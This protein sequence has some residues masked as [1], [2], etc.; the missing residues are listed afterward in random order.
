MEPIKEIWTSSYTL[1]EQASQKERTGL[2]IK[3][4]FSKGII[5]YNSIQPLS[6]F[7]EGMLSDYI[8]ILK[9]IPSKNIQK[10]KQAIW[11]DTILQ[12]AYMDATARSKGQSLLFGYPL[13]QS[14][15][16]ISNINLWNSLDE[17]PFNVF[18]IKMGSHLT[19]ENLKLRQIIENTKKKFQIRLDFNEKL[20]KKQWDKWEKE[21][22]DLISYID[23]IED[24]F[25]NFSYTPSFFHLAGDWCQPHHGITRVLKPSRHKL[26]QILKELAISK[27][28]RF[29]FTHSLSHPLE[30]RLS[31]VKA[32][33]FYKIHPR[34][35]EVCG[36]H[37][38][39]NFYR[40]NDFSC[41]YTNFY[42]P[43]GTGLGFDSLLSRQKWIRLI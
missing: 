30:A 10:N 25:V 32:S 14:H 2:L 33:Q 28:Q 36:L 11:I 31:W 4:L 38:P 37:Y 8:E 20:S 9:N 41:F 39:L 18:K 24:P 7:R 12:D 17:I 42:A 27:F 3:V 23:F 16:L 6:H 29:I 34:K 5:G 35:K 40:K 26:Q 1:T 15:Y 21:N 22:K 19:K 13:I 43:L